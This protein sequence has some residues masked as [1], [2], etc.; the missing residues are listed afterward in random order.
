MDTPPRAGEYRV[1][2]ALAAMADSEPYSEA[3]ALSHDR[4]GHALSFATRA[5]ENWLQ[6][7]VGIATRSSSRRLGEALGMAYEDKGD[8]ATRG[9]EVNAEA[10]P[11]RPSVFGHTRD[12]KQPK[13]SPPRGFALNAPNR[14]DGLE[15][16][17]SW[18]P[19]ASLYAFSTR[20]TEACS[21]SKKVRK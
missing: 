10:R 4:R 13:V 8:L 20:S 2:D 14:A 6:A 19:R 12:L 17:R 16:L 3:A 21:I 5:S 1:M 9:F 7:C 11:L 15:L 18:N